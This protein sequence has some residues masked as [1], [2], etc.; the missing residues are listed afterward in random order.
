MDITEE[1]KSWHNA[2]SELS[3]VDL[4]PACNKGVL[5]PKTSFDSA[6]D[7]NYIYAQCSVC[8]YSTS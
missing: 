4:C 5:V 7:D 8:N 1:R 3:R 6:N 2:E